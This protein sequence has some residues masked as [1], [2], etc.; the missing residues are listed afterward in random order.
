GL[1]RAHVAARKEGIRI[2]PGCRL[3]L[4]DG[5]PLLAYPTNKQAYSRLS[6]MLT[7]GN[8]RTEKGSCL[9]YKEDVYRW[10]EDI[11][12]IVLPPATL[13]EQFD[14]P[15]AFSDVVKEYRSRL[16]GSLYLGA[17][18]VYQG[19]DAKRIFRLSQLS[20]QLDI[21]LV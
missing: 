15:Q 20:K 21:P 14:F 11:K 16:G 3:D 7:E 5:P 13:N 17:A 9:L 19:N 2:I 4:Q 1:V 8:L 10:S 18:F 12:F 6:S